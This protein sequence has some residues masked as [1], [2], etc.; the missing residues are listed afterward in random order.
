MHLLEKLRADHAEITAIRRDIH[1]HP[2]LA[3]EEHRTAAIV[4]ERLRALGI[5]THTG[6]GKTG[7]VG[8]LQGRH[9]WPRHRP[10]GRHGRAAHPGEERLQPALPPPRA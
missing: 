3:F 10:A 9:Q 1:A 4:A 2:E 7:V 5:E 6:V 8:V